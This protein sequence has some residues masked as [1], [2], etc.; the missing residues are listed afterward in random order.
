MSQNFARALAG[1]CLCAA[2]TLAAVAGAPALAQNYPDR[3]IHLVVPYGPGGNTDILG[4]VAAQKLA[5]AIGQQV[6]IDNKPGAYTLLGI[7]AAAA[8]PADGYTL[9]MGNNST[10]I[11]PFIYPGPAGY[12]FSDWRAIGAVGTVPMVLD[13]PPAMNIKSI[14][15]LVAYDKASP[16]RLNIGQVGG[17]T[18]LLSERLK[19]V[20]GLK[21]VDINFGSAAQALTNIAGN[22]VQVMIDGAPTSIALHKGGKIRIIAVASDKRLA[23]LPDVPTFREQGFGAMTTSAWYALF[24]PAKVPAPVFERLAAAMARALADPTVKERMVGAGGEPW[25]GTLAE[26]DAYIKRDAR[27]LEDDARR[28]GYKLPN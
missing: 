1:T 23:A 27:E 26:F 22:Q 6:I 4:R 13:V 21:L 8:A 2:A 5:D 12:A 3:P 19:F 17:H 9:L 16:G 18:Q 15:E 14:A 7:R 20:T 25:S 28:S 10:A 24:A 11:L